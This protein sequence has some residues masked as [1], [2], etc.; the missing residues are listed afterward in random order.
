MIII[1]KVKRLNSNL[2]LTNRSENYSYFGNI[3]KVKPLPS[4]KIINDPTIV[5][6]IIMYTKLLFLIIN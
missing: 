2:R 5:F 6:F 4:I 1:N 3:R